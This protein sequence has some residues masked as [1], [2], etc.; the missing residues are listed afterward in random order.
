MGKGDDTTVGKREV[1]RTNALLL[2]NQPSDRPE[3]DKEVNERKEKKE[4]RR[5]KEVGPVNFSCQKSL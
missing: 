3:K 2:G 5:M 1:E 4:K